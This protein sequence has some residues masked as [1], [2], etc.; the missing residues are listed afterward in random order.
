MEPRQPAVRR[1]VPSTPAKRFSRSSTSRTAIV[2]ARNRVPDVGEIL[3]PSWSPDGKSIA[4]S[5]TVGGDS[6]LFV[7]DLTANTERRLTSDL[8]ADLQPAWSPDGAKIAFVTD[9][10]STKAAQLAAGEYQLALL[11]VASGRIA[12]LTT[13]RASARASTRNGHPDGRR[14]YFIS[15]RTGISNVYSLDVDSGATAQLDER[16]CRRQRHHGAQPGDLFGDR[17]ADA[18]DQRLRERSYHIYLDRHASVRAGRRSQATDRLEAATLPPLQRESMVAQLLADPLI[19]TAARSRRK[20]KPY[21]PGLSLDAVGQPYITAGVDR[22]GG[23]LGGGI[24]L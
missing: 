9:R 15:D 1:A 13:F 10:F 14:L 24:A 7:Y 19:G 8:F 16:R 23:M 17:R 6:D 2:V 21:K 20:P 22:F 11:D 3:N 12:P 4:F 5:A 18:R